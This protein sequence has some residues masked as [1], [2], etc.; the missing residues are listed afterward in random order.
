MYVC[1]CECLGIEREQFVIT[2]DPITELMWCATA[3]GTGE[4]SSIIQHI[5]APLANVALCI[6]R[7]YV[8]RWVIPKHLPPPS[9]ASVEKI[10]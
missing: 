5:L 4:R 8:D 2:S 6:W 9:E 3:G 1:M 7:W 10:Y